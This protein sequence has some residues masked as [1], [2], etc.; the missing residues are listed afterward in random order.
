MNTIAKGKM[1]FKVIH[2]HPRHDPKKLKE[3][4]RQ[5]FKI[6]IK[7]EGKTH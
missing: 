5:L 4:E 6:F 3:I 2:H 7:Y 1:Q